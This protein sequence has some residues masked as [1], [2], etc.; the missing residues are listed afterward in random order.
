[1]PSQEARNRSRPRLHIE[2]NGEEKDNAM[3]RAIEARCTIYLA[4]MNF[5]LRL[6]DTDIKDTEEELQSDLKTEKFFSRRR[7]YA[8]FQILVKNLNGKTMA[9]RVC[10]TDTIHDV[11]DKIQD[12]EGF[13][14]EQLRITFAGK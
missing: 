4:D 6:E 3:K 7:K 14:L 2:V 12:R 9:L 1:M 5:S 8:N 13:P 11:K 10:K